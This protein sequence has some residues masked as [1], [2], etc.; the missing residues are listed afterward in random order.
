MTDLIN[1]VPARKKKEV[2]Y[3]IFLP[4]FIFSATLLIII[5]A[6]FFKMIQIRLIWLTIFAQTRQKKFIYD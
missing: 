5:F 1:F 4:D 6:I 3:I 2:E